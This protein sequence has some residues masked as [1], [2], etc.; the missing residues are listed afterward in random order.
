MKINNE[1]G[2]WVSGA[3]V[4]PRSRAKGREQATVLCGYQ[5]FFTGTLERKVCGNKGSQDFPRQRWH[6]G[7]RKRWHPNCFL[8][9][10]P[11]CQSG[12]M[13]ERG[14]C[15]C[16]VGP[17]IW[18][19]SSSISLPKHG[20]G[21]KDYGQV[22]L[23]WCPGAILPFGKPFLPNGFGQPFSEFLRS[24]MCSED[25][26]AVRL[27]E[28]LLLVDHLSPTLAHLPFPKRQPCPPGRL[29]F[30][31]DSSVQ[32]PPQVSRSP[33]SQV[34]KEPAVGSAR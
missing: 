31:G 10:I 33:E 22:D 29:G 1:H 21:E 11:A 14:H 17:G 7:G 16:L 23:F 15:G 9:A 28:A 27:T 2:V 30:I 6:S 12:G 4:V 3:L 8:P 25:R 20:P 32:P 18:L 5:C 19:S 34:C 24:P 13:G 26:R